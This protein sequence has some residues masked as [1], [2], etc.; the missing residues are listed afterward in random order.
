MMPVMQG[1]IEPPKNSRNQRRTTTKTKLFTNGI[2]AA[3]QRQNTEI[4][5]VMMR[6]FF[7]L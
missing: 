1:R 7:D 4:I 3:L 5:I 2:G 6:D